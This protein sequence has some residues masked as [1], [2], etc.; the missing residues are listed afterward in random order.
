M[1]S[2]VTSSTVS[3]TVNSDCYLR[4][5]DNKFHQD[6]NQSN[7]FAELWCESHVNKM[8]TI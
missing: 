8:F 1:T 5:T 6:Q 7:I 3:I 4:R 2:W